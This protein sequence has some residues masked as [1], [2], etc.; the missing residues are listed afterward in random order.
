MT[1]PFAFDRSWV[2]PLSPHQMWETL[3]RTEDFP[4]WW[5]WLR[6]FDAVP[7]AE[8]E[9]AHCTIV[10]PLP[11]T[12]RLDISV[13]KATPAA[14]VETEITGDLAGPARLEI[15]G[16]PGGSKVRLAWSLEPRRALLVGL[17]RLARPV[18]EWGH[19]WVVDAGIKQFRHRLVQASSH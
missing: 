6:Q 1:P 7:L 13:V 11:Y 8:G 14:L 12:L 9:T 5:P 3:S 2:F 16:A 17:A 10:P 19:E 4:Q 18:L 15:A